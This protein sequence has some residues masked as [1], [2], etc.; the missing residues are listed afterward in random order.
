MW[1]VELTTGCRMTASSTLGCHYSRTPQREA[2]ALATPFWQVRGDVVIGE[3]GGALGN[4]SV[5]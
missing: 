4:T 3:G 2:L 1:T 5:F